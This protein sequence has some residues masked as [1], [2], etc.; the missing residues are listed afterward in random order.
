MRDEVIN[1]V[2]VFL[3]EQLPDFD[4]EKRQD[5][6]KV[7]I[8][9]SHLLDVSDDS[10]RAVSFQED[11]DGKHTAYSRKFRNLFSKSLT[12][13]MRI[14]GQSILIFG[15]ES[16]LKL[17]SAFLLLIPVLYDSMKVVFN[18]MD[19]KVIRAIF[20]LGKKEFSQDELEAKL[21]ELFAADGDL[22]DRVAAILKKLCDAGVLRSRGH[23]NYR[24]REPIR[25]R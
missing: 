18:E 6:E 13:W 25:A 9:L 19:A 8:V 14:F 7:W 24:V 17:A 21:R 16:R 12:E 2:K 3:K 11:S 15:I 20:E 10:H 1:E 22:P 5:D 23:G 4:P